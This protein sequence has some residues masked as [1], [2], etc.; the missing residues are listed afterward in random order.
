MLLVNADSKDRSPR[1]GAEEGLSRGREHL[2]FSSLRRKYLVIRDRV[3]S[4]ASMSH[5][6]SGLDEGLICFDN[7][8]RE[9]EAYNDAHMNTSRIV[10][11]SS[12]ALLIMAVCGVALTAEASHSWGGYHWARTATPFTLKLGD[13]VGGVWDAYLR[14]AANDWNADPSVLYPGAGIAQALHTTVVP[15]GTTA[16]NCRAISGTVQVCNNSYGNT[17]WLGIAQI[18]ISGTHI[19]Q[20]TAKLNDTYFNTAK[21]NTSAWRNMVMCQEIAHT[22]GLDHQDEAFA[23]TNLGTC[24]D[25]TNAPAGGIYNGFDYGLSNEHPNTHDYE[26]LGL[27]YAHLD[28]NTT[29][30]LSKASRASAVAQSD[31]FENAAEWGKVIRTSRDGKESLYI[32]DLGN[33][34]KVMTFVIWAQ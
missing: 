21:Y 19:T 10:A 20:G 18:S 4:L 15:G 30:S 32:R 9:F 6:A 24:M 8:N 22:F 28:T 27:I 3:P 34:T 16:R 29:V 12:V 2:V 26:E 31:D 25:Y 13:N 11:G 14:S 7:D 17:G 1:P 33:D 23:N 5:S